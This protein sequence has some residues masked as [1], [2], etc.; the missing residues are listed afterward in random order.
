M[1]TMR[2]IYDGYRFFGYA[3]PTIQ[4][5]Q[6]DARRRQFREI[7]ERVAGPDMKYG[8]HAARVGDAQAVEDYLCAL[9]EVGAIPYRERYKRRGEG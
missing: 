4:G 9:V 5:G 2:Q 6:F 3:I 1:Q 8:Q 7:N